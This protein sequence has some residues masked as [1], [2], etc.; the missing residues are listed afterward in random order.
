VPLAVELLLHCPS[1]FLSVSPAAEVGN[2]GPYAEAGMPS[3][4]ASAEPQTQPRNKIG[5]AVKV[6]IVIIHCMRHV[7][8]NTRVDQ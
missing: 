8:P 7:V 3:S 1:S 5:S 2:L 4:T 6:A